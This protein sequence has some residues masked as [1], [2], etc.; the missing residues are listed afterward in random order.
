MASTSTNQKAAHLYDDEPAFIYG[1]AWKK[2][3]TKRLVKEALSQS[4][5]AVGACIRTIQTTPR[6][7]TALV[8]SIL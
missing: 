6:R 2:D 1:A 3:Q 7:D 5:A 4:L 8:P